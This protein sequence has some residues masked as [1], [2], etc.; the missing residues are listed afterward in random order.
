MGYHTRDIPKGVLGELSKIDEEYMEL[1][2]ASSQGAK[3]L[4]LCELCDLIG[5]IEAYV[6]NHHNLSLDDLIQMKDLTAQA[7]RDGSRVSQ[8]PD[9][10]DEPM[11]L[12]PI[13]M[14]QGVPRGDLGYGYVEPSPN[15]DYASDLRRR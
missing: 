2:D 15:S 3:M 14:P 6:E 9:K 10:K 13:D 7:F 4:I 11:V 1:S 5:A 12:T 8:P